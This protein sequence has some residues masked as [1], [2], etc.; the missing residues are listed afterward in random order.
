MQCIYMKSPQTKKGLNSNLSELHFGKSNVD[1]YRTLCPKMLLAF[2]RIAVSTFKPVVSSG[3]YSSSNPS[4]SPSSSILSKCIHQLSIYDQER[5]MQGNI[6]VS[7][8]HALNKCIFRFISVK[9][10]RQHSERGFAS[11]KHHDY[12]HWYAHKAIKVRA[13]SQIPV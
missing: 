10:S 7:S 3:C 1:T 9:I 4:S 12:K 5:E 8:V 13:N 2:N 6:H 11:G